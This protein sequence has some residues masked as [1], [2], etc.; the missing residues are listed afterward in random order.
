[1]NILKK[2]LVSCLLISLTS[3]SLE[4]QSLSIDDEVLLAAKADS[5]LQQSIN[6][7]E[8]AGL[9]AGVYANGKIIWEGGAGFRNVKQ[10]LPAEANMIHRIASIAKPMTAI[11]I[12][13]LVE[14]GK[15]DLD[16]PIQTYVQ[17]FPVK[18]NNTIT[19]RH[20]LTHTSG[21]NAYKNWWDSFSR[22]EYQTLLDAMGRFKDRKR[23][24]EPGKTYKYTT[25]GYVVLGVIIEKVSGMDYETYMK[26]YVWKPSGMLH[27]SIERYKVSVENKSSL[28][29]LKKNG[30]IKKEWNTNLSMKVPGGGL[31]STVGDLLRFGEAVLTHKLVSEATL[32]IML[33]DPGIRPK[34]DGNPYG[35]GW[36]LYDTPQEQRVIGHSGSQAGTTTQL[37]ILP[38]QGVVVACMSNTRRAEVMRLAWQLIN[39]TQQKEALQIPIFAEVKLNAQ[40]MDRFVG[41]YGF[42]NSK[43]GVKI[44]RKGGQ[45]YSVDKM[46]NKRLKLY[47][48]SA[49]KLFYRSFNGWYDFEIDEKGKVQNATYHQNGEKVLAKKIK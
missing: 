14:Q 10:S 1:M 34:Q 36:F 6:F 24:G 3:L 18:N 4:S 30:K 45:L 7:N 41:F 35:M 11:A 20:L 39:Y 21:I 25:Y 28:Y 16:V 31:Q 5:L 38:D 23:V 9:T 15:I 17:E 48:A 2:L 49:T 44:Y 33:E 42:E 8:H 40:A 43:N 46:Q 29:K 12:M 19:V 26:E 22:K 27:T 47:A 32:E 37:L 13:Q